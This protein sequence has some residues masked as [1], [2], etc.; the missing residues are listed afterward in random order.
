MGEAIISRAGGGS[1]DDPIA[2]VPG[3]HSL[4]VKLKTEDGNPIDNCIINCKDG[5]TWYNY[6]TNEKGQALFM[7]NSGTAN[8]FINNVVNGIQYC[9][10]VPTNV[11]VDAPVG[12]KTIMNIIHNRHKSVEFLSSTDFYIIS[13]RNTNI[14]L[15]GGGGGGGGG[16]WWSKAEVGYDGSGGGGGYI[17]SYK[18]ELYG[19]YHFI[20]G[21]GGRGGKYIYNGYN[22]EVIGGAGGTSYI[23]NTSFSAIGGAGGTLNNISTN[24]PLGGT[25]NGSNEVYRGENSPVSFGGGGGGYYCW[26]RSSYSA[27]NTSE[28]WLI[29]NLRE[30]YKGN[31]YFGGRPCGG[32]GA[33]WIGYSGSGDIWGDVRAE[34]GQRGGG[35]GGMMGTPDHPSNNAGDGGDGMLHIDFLE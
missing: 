27:R 2:V 11:N 28:S 33:I 14:S 4:L 26:W 7:C 21:A 12:Q 10:I 30:N 6:K 20:A 22:S 18:T 29:S 19:K 31:S 15:I 24:M 5:S 8:L 35:G 1:S 23:E 3:Y 17:N 13:K 9:D 25:G 16:V 32:N 34:S